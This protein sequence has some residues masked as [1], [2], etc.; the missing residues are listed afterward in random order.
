MK[1]D[2]PTHRPA[3]RRR[4]ISVAIWL[5]VV[6]GVGLLGGLA[7]RMPPAAASNSGS[8]GSPGVSGITNG[9]WWTPDTTWRVAKNSLDTFFTPVTNSLYR[10]TTPP[11]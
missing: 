2:R 3:M 11:T 10:T 4:I 5:S 1:E 9:V 8:A 6:L 7:H